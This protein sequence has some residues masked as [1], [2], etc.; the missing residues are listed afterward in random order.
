MQRI[1]ETGVLGFCGI[2]T[3]ARRM[4]AP[5]TSSTSEQRDLWLDEVVTL[6][7]ESVA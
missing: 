1:W 3:V 5:V 7:R 4:Y 6:V 2:T